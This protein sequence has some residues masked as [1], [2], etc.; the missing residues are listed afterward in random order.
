[1]EKDSKIY[2]AGHEGMVGSALVRS[3]KK[4]NY[5]NIINRTRAELD[6]MSQEKTKKFFF[7]EKPDYVFIAAA[8]VGGILANSLYKGQFLYENLLIQN[9]L[10]HFAHETGVKK[11]MFLGSACIYPQNNPQ[12]IK[13]EALL[14]GVLEPTNEAYAISKIAG[15]KLCQ[16]YY[17]QYGD[18]FISLMPNNLYGPNDNFDLENSHVIPAMIR[19]VHEAKINSLNNVEIWGTG[20][21]LREFLHVD[22]L[23]DSAIFLIKNLEAKELYDMEISHI[24]IGSGEEISIK[25]LAI[26]IKEVVDFHGDLIFNRNM[27]DGMKRKLLDTSRLNKLGWRSQISLN[28]GIKSVYSWYKSQK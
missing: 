19:K 7:M 24:N 14:S 16:S 5:S 15:I 12:P 17:D 8:K 10:I 11:L 27:P 9:N 23:A 28:D 22:V 1:M 6:L 2:V 21:P 18:N 13:E 3:L 26:L 25:D 4:N 20:S